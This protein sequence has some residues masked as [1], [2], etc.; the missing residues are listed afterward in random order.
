MKKDGTIVKY[1]MGST[2]FISVK[3]FMRTLGLNPK[4]ERLQI[5]DADG[6]WILDIN[7]TVS[8]NYLLGNSFHIIKKS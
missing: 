5:K 6:D 4:K 1:K 8:L 7:C 3:H 2:I